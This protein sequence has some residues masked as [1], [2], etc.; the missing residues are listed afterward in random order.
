MSNGM[1][2]GAAP[3][4]T[5]PT[6]TNQFSNGTR[7][8]YHSG[9]PA[10]TTCARCGKPIC[11]DC[12]D[13]YSVSSGE[14]EGQA[15][16]YDCCR[17]LVADNIAL[18][19][20]NKGKIKFHFILS[21]IGMVIGFILGIVFGVSG[22]ADTGGFF[23]GILYG[24]LFAAIGGVFWS[25][26]KFW[27][28]CLWVTIKESVKALAD[29]GGIWAVIGIMFVISFRVGIETIKCF[30]YT[31]RNT[32]DYIKYIKETEGFIESDTNSLQQMD[33][34]M[35]YTL[36]RNQNKSVDLDILLGQS[37]ELANN[38][39]ARMVQERGEEGAEA[40]LRECVATIN[41]NGEIIRSFNS[42]GRAA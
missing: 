17:E 42:T 41:E 24:L 31:I 9:E 11:Q 8:H 18:L 16:C 12:F 10:V 38:S 29:G 32:I 39:Y 19:K 37:K 14:Y 40:A 25:F 15:L 1:N 27:L 13:N 6:N 33:D 22:G 23:G 20:K 7:C 36:V 4:F 26:F 35:Q 2:M 21:I 28:S 5:P 34:Y 30:Y 3:I